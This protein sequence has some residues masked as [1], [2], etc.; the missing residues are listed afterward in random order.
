[1]AKPTRTSGSEVS[2]TEPQGC[3]ARQTNGANP[4]RTVLDA[5][6]PAS[7][8]EGNTETDARRFRV[9]PGMGLG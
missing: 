8:L 6:N 5:D 3:E 1:M 7:G 9:E 4:S 2:A